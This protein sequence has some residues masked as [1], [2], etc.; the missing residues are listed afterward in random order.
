M[1]IPI[2]AAV[3]KAARS[4]ATRCAYFWERRTPGKQYVNARGQCKRTTAHP[5]GYCSAHRPP[6]V[7]RGL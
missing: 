3:R 7:S 1:K 6:E 4:K 2:G 5:S